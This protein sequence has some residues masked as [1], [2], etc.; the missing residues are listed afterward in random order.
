MKFVTLAI[1][2]AVFAVAAHGQAMQATPA[3]C[4]DCERFNGMM[5]GLAQHAFPGQGDNRQADMEL[6]QRLPANLQQSCETS[7]QMYGMQGVQTLISENPAKLCPHVASCYEQG[8]LPQQQFP[9]YG[10]PAMD[11]AAQQTLLSVDEGEEDEAHAD[12]HEEDEN[13]DEDDSEE[14][15]DD[16]DED[17]DDD[18]EE[19]NPRLAKSAFLEAAAR[20][21]KGAAQGDHD[22]LEA[23]KNMGS[24][25]NLM[26][27]INSPL[28]EVGSNQAFEDSLQSADDMD[29]GDSN[30]Y[31]A[32]SGGPPVDSHELSSTAMMLPLLNTGGTIEAMMAVGG[33]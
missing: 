33:M 25:I 18:E 28:L 8:S 12:E 17:D 26:S 31:Q 13:D 22:D 14:D 9:A 30:C 23:I 20:L 3:Q 19:E 16:D 21:Q 5:G 15:K 1:V 24:I 32:E 2:F 4:A 10:Q 6:C 29:C 7:I 27:A 11:P